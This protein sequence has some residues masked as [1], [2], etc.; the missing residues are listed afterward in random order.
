V[1]QNLGTEQADSAVRL[2]SCILEMHVFFLARDIDCTEV[3]MVFT[4]PSRLIK[5]RYIKLIFFVILYY[6]QSVPVGSANY[7]LTYAVAYGRVVN[8]AP[9]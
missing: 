9:L 1:K 7:V 5:F 6:L 8:T 2:L 4:S 3:S